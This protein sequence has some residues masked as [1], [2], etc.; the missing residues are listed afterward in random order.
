MIFRD[1]YGVTHELAP[2]PFAGFEVRIT[3]LI[4]GVPDTEEKLGGVVEVAEEDTTLLPQFHALRVEAP[5]NDGRVGS[6]RISMHEPLLED[7]ALEPYQ[8]ALWIGFWR[9]GEYLAEA[10]FWGQCNVK[11]FYDDGYVLLEGQDPYAGKARSHYIRRGDEALNIDPERGKLPAHAFSTE[12]I[13]DAARN[14]QPQQD[15]SMP[16][17]ALAEAY[18]DS[19]LDPAYNPDATPADVAGGD[20][21]LIEFER[22]QEVVDLHQQIVSSTAGPDID[23]VPPFTW[24]GNRYADLYL[25]RPPVSAGHPNQLG[26]NL[27]PV[28]PDDPQPDEIVWSYGLPPTDEF[29][30]RLDN[31]LDV[32]IEPGKPITHVHYLDASRRYR[33][34]VADAES[35]QLIGAWV[36]FNIA[37][38][39]II[40]PSRGVAADLTALRELA[41]AIVKSYG[42]PPK[43]MRVKLARPDAPGMQQFGHPDWVGSVGGEGV[44]RIGGS[45]YLGDYVRVRAKRGARFFSGLGRITKAIL[46]QSGPND[47]PE[48]EV[49]LVPA[50]GGTPGEDTDYPDLL[51]AVGPSITITAPAD[52]ATVAGSVTISAS[53]TAAVAI[54]SVEFY[55]N[56]VSVGAGSFDVTAPYTVSWDTTA[57]TDGA[58][59]LTARVTDTGG[60]SALSDPVDVVIANGVGGGSEGSASGEDMPTGDI[61]GWRLIFSDD[62]NDDIALG[63]FPSVVAD[64]WYAY[65]QGWPDTSHNGRYDAPRTISVHD[66]VM[67]MHLHT[68]TLSG[69]ARHLVCAPLPILPAGD[70]AVIG[71]SP[72]SGLQYGRYVVRFRAVDVMEGYKTAWLLWPL[73]DDHPH[74]GEIDFPEGDLGAGDHIFAFM[75]RQDGVSDSDQ[76]GADSGVVF[77]G[78]GWHTTVIE[79]GPTECRFEMDGDLVLSVGAR[80]PSTPMRWVLQTETQ[81]SGGAP[82]S[83]VQGHI[84]IDWVAVFARVP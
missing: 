45:W 5:V 37:D 49:E 48:Y 8:Q 9:P 2:A 7:L 34:T 54:A 41:T 33:V 20:A 22:G 52:G 38:F 29:P 15:R 1:Q 32:H 42:V 13:F 28:D 74:D 30:N 31:A 39:T 63:S 11:D 19:F 17:L 58:H 4:L 44:E 65:P 80:I 83:A 23:V 53:A 47:L 43:H 46:S 12:D 78:S 70:P 79:W 55:V 36:S 25:Y 57:L 27:D 16:A 73:S 18:Y 81:L 69:V 51:D 66:G 67:D 84:E 60:R 3:P 64:R 68:E 24:P 40:R 10:I 75:H 14:T 76:D 56:G 6:V 72:W 71:S 26:R 35:S 61:T 62:F 21:A 50:I 82:S 59:A 77:A